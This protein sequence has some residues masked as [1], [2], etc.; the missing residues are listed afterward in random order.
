MYINKYLIDSIG[1]VIVK[2]RYAKNKYTTEYNAFSDP[3][4]ILWVSPDDIEYYTSPDDNNRHVRS[5][6]DDKHFYGLP[7][8]DPYHGSVVRGGFRNTL[9]GTVQHGSWD[10][11]TQRFTDTPTYRGLK[12]YFIDGVEWDQTEYFQLMSK[13]IKNGHVD[14]VSSIEELSSS[15]ISRLEDLYND[16][17]ENGYKT[18]NQFNPLFYEI[19][20]NFG[21]NGEL[22]FNNDGH[23]RLSISKILDVD[24]VAVVVIARHEKWQQ[25]RE[26]VYKSYLNGSLHNIE[27]PILEHPDIKNM[28]SSV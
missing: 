10:D 11:K 19:D 13:W 27:E 4:E 15:H 5:P 23:H 2:S 20:V 7:E 25:K 14:N 1:Y 16:I 28:L 26:Y 8:D 18:N 3:F 21:R 17:K 24:K 9:A 6:E 22:L 12:Q